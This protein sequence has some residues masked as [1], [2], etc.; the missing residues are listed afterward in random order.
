MIYILFMLLIFC[1]FIFYI[2]VYLMDNKSKKYKL[3][4]SVLKNILIILFV[5]FI[6][7]LLLL[8]INTSNDYKTIIFSIIAIIISLFTLFYNHIFFDKKIKI[9][10]GIREESVFIEIEN[11]SNKDIKIEDIIINNKKLI[12]KYNIENNGKKYIEQSI[13]DIEYFMFNYD[14]FIKLNQ[15]S[16]IKI[17]YSRNEN[18]ETFEVLNVKL[19][20]SYKTLFLNMKKTIET[21]L[22]PYV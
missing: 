15:G 22:S 4:K 10:K 6:S 3:L 5:I 19:E 14:E 12:H 7:Y 13:D 1:F 20:C 9:I 8:F 18:C 2:L 16:N 21:D 11:L 17:Q